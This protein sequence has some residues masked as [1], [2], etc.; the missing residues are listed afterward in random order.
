[1]KKR[2]AFLL[3]FVLL[4][5]LVAC[6]G[7]TT[8]APPDVLAGDTTEEP[9]TPEAPVT[10]GEETEE[11]EVWDGDYE[12][13]TFD[14]IRKFGFGSSKWD[15]SLPL[16][17]TG[18]K[19]EIGMR[20]NGSVTDY[21]TNPMT[22]WIEETTGV[23]VVIKSFMGSASDYSTQISLMMT[24]GEELPDILYIQGEGNDRRSEYVE[25]GYLLNVA[26]YYMTDSYYFAKAF[27]EANSSVPEKYAT[28]LN[29]I[30]QYCA[31][32]KTGKMYGSVNILDDP[33][34]GIYTEAMINDVWLEKLNLSKPTTID[35]LYNVLVAFRDQDPNGNGKKDEV[36][37]MGIVGQSYGR[38]VNTYLINAFIQYV[39]SQKAMIEN[40]KAFSYHDQ[41]E[42]RQALIFMNK[43]LNEGLLSPLAFTGNGTDLRNMLNPTGGK[44]DV[45]GICC[46]WIAGDFMD[47]SDSWKRYSP[48]PALADCTG[49]GGFSMIDA[50]NVNTIYGL[51][52]YCENP[53]LCWRL[54]DVLHSEEGY[55][56]T[57]WGEEGVDWDYIENTEFKDMA[58]GNGA[59]GG[60]ARFVI[61]N[62]G[63]R[64]NSRWF[65][66]CTYV[67]VKNFQI[68]IH[69]TADDYTS[70]FWRNLMEDVRIQEEIGGPPEQFQ[71][72]LR[73][74]EE[75]E[76][77][78]EFNA[79]L[80]SIVNTARTQFAMGIMDPNDDAQWQE[81]LDDLKA[82]KFERWAEL[83]QAS[84]D[85]Q[86]VELEAIR[87]RLEKK[88]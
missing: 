20:A 50:A 42:Y 4:L 67:N 22:L 36:P 16:T 80:S 63:F 7:T 87:A 13:A 82:L 48:L 64:T 5:G 27:N 65:Y 12:T 11:P 30:F 88:V 61:H 79:E 57:R 14:D 32:Q 78:H 73:T 40:G 71:V 26:G 37:L 29:N 43:L 49:R 19:V 31:N 70:T 41:D 77:F 72:F 23:D 55:L 33:T 21:D 86:Q 75:D 66:N 3:T 52:S 9:E 6:G 25:E 38:S 53:Q 35:E 69:P 83:A 60:T 18:E 28:M 51:T 76:L 46:C 17:T 59:Y 8:T 1:M 10:P 34:E 81:Y 58:E 24:G 44:P 74:P 39:P 56:V 84:Y 47:Y 54:L 85:R 62:Q 15:G 68:F 45:V 2:I